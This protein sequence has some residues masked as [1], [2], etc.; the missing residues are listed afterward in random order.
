MKS[1]K[2]ILPLIICLSLILSTFN[3]V[4]AKSLED[5][6]IETLNAESMQEDYG[7]S[8]MAE[9]SGVDETLPTWSTNPTWEPINSDLNNESRYTVL[10][11]IL[12]ST[13][14][15]DRYVRLNTDISVSGDYGYGIAV[16]GKKVLDLNGHKLSI[17]LG[18]GEGYSGRQTAISISSGATLMIIDSKGGGKIFG[19]TWICDPVDMGYNRAATDL[20]YNKGTLIIHMPNGEIETGRSKKQ[21]VTAAAEDGEY[22]DIAYARY[23]GYI[24]GQANGTAI[25]GTKNS[26]TVLVSGRV[27]GQGFY[28]FG[29]DAW[30]HDTPSEKCAAIETKGK[31]IMYGGE[32]LGSGG[33]DALRAYGGKNNTIVYSGKFRVKSLDKMAIA[34]YKAYTPRPN[35]T[36]ECGYGYPISG[37]RN[38]AIGSEIIVGDH[39]T[40]VRPKS[41]TETTSDTVRLTH[42]Y[43]TSI[44]DLEKQSMWVVYAYYT[45]CF[46]QSGRNYL[47]YSENPTG[48]D[49]N[50][51][52]FWKATAKFTV[53]NHIGKEI[54]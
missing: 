6:D 38:F 44:I 34:A 42:S 45:P 53:L 2:V 29:T 11:K 47:G 36:K 14:S 54:G 3:P 49:Y 33:A 30:N 32:I 1:R 9:A 27:I 12:E 28:K 41:E 4:F 16:K 20:I 52:T 21:W 25:I 10:M 15:G 24:R 26:K 51:P 50:V 35:F 31:F 23:S 39:E 22:P 13:G 17:K 37:E 43:G 48:Y 5:Y 8:L 19:D 40:T 18:K 7:L 46:L